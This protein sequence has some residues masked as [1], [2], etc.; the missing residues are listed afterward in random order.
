MFGEED[1]MPEENLVEELPASNT[2]QSFV[3]LIVP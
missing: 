2:M 1:D 3:L